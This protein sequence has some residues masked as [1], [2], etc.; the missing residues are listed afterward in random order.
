MALEATIE[1]MSPNGLGSQ[2]TPLRG[3]R[4]F[5][6]FVVVRINR[7]GTILQ[8][9]EGAEKLTGYSRKELLK[10]EFGLQLVHP[11]D[12]RVVKR[13]IRQ[14]GLD[15]QAAATI[16]L[17]QKDGTPRNVEIRATS[18]G[19]DFDLVLVDVVSSSSLFNELPVRS[20]YDDAEPMLRNIALASSDRLTFLEDAL[21]LM[22]RTARADGGHILMAN[23]DESL[24]SVAFWMEEHV[25]VIEPVELDPDDWPELLAGRVANITGDDS[26]TAVELLQAIGSVQAVLVPFRD[27]GGRDGAILLEWRTD[28]PTWSTQDSRALAR[29]ARLFETLW[30]WMD[31]EARHELTLSDLE[32]GLFNFSFG[33]GGVRRYA[34]VTPQFEMITGVTA[35]NLIAGS[36]EDPTLSWSS[37]VFEEDVENFRK[38]NDRLEK[39]VRSQ[40]EYRIVHPETGQIRWIRESATPSRTATGQP[41]IGGLLSD[42]TDRKRSEATLLQAKN[43]AEK[44][45]HAKTAFMATMSHEIRSPLGA[46]RGFAELMREEF[47]D[48]E[49]RGEKLPEEIQEFAGIISENTSRVLHLVHSL[50]DLSRLESG[51]MELQQLPIELHSTVDRVLLKHRPKAEAKGLSVVFE[52]SEGDPILMGDPERVEEIV[53]HLISNAIKFTHEGGVI[54]STRLREDIVEFEVQDTGIGIAAEYLDKLFEPFTQ[55][56]YRLNRKYEGSGLGLAITKRLLNGMGGSIAV[57]SAKGKGSRFVVIFRQRETNDDNH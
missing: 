28:P 18:N 19:D 13:A 3:K 38:H 24:L 15:G 21:S 41:V 55:E 26:Q 39:G 6:P 37:L 1:H 33:N 30:A 25:D 47:K 5:L 7:Q 42:I 44:A 2:S 23:N 27:E 35:S 20:R 48:A 51:A 32:D 36:S 31:S 16:Q 43:A 52:R 50:F 53:D 11:D 40:A 57:E 45:S 54:I 9:G 56:D 12:H 4:E 34:F 29:L 10:P 22:A 8:V 14:I 49:S 46:I 17:I